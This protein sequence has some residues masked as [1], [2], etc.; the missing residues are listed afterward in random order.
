MSKKNKE[1]IAKI[2]SFLGKKDIDASQVSQ[3][4]KTSEF[5]YSNRLQDAKWMPEG[6]ERKACLEELEN[7]VSLLIN[8]GKVTSSTSLNTLYRDAAYIS[9]ALNRFDKAMAY[10]EK[11]LQADSNDAYSYVARADAYTRKGDFQKAIMDYKKAISLFPMNADFYCHLGHTYAL[12][13][14]F[15]DAVSAY[16]QAIDIN[17][18]NPYN[19]AGRAY[20][21]TCL[22]EWDEAISDYNDAI[23]IDCEDPELFYGRA[24]IYLDMSDYAKSLSDCNKAIELNEE[25]GKYHYIKGCAL[26]GEKKYDDSLKSFDTAIDNQ[27]QA[28]LFYYGRAE[29]Y[30]AMG[31][32]QKALSDLNECKSLDE[33]NK[34]LV[35]E[36]LD[37]IHQAY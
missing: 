2:L 25:E 34:I 32:D 1:G 5:P 16:S 26:F 10:Y 29:V 31:E 37:T 8:S 17:P 27:P 12:M 24:C 19:F 22:E 15:D 6:D 28:S 11:A 9:F 33:S 14:I 20:V 23:E 4:E 18:F 36:M 21:Y 35:Q 7:E 30:L 13:R 3:T